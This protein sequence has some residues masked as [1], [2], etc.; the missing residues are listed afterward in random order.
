MHEK[1][2]EKYEDQLLLLAGERVKSGKFKVFDPDAHINIKE[3]RPEIVERGHSANEFSLAFQISSNM[4][5]AWI[6]SQ[7][8]P[9]YLEFAM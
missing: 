7:Y 5:L 6:E 3:H 1:H 9:K 4:S 8:K 2:D